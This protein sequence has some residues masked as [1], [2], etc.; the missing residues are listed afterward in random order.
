MHKLKIETS[1]GAYELNINDIISRG[2]ESMITTHVVNNYCQNDMILRIN[3]P[4]KLVI[5]LINAYNAL[6]YNWP[7]NADYYLLKQHVLVEQ[8][9]L[10]EYFQPR[11]EI[12]SII[13]AVRKSF[14]PT[15]DEKEANAIMENFYIYAK[16]FYDQAYINNESTKENLKAYCAFKPVEK[17]SI[18]LLHE[19]CKLTVIQVN[20]DMSRESFVFTPN[21]YKQPEGD[22]AFCGAFIE[23]L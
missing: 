23:N 18:V 4:S 10:D 19:P 9:M 21:S 16:Y 12:K 5:K 7:C 14:P 13:D 1:D 22:Y 17:K 2:P 8:K 20:E 3:Y 11:S 15:T 6:M